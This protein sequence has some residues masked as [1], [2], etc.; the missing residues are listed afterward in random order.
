MSAGRESRLRFFAAKLRGFFRGYE[1]DRELDD[2]ILEHLRLLADKF[3]EQGMSRE[4]AVVAAR[5]QFGN[6]TLLEE[7]RR[8]LQTL[9]SIEALWLDLRYALCIL[10]RS[11]GFAVVSIAT[12]GL[13]IGAATAIFSVID[14]V[15]LQPFPKVRAAWCWFVSSE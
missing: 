5:R 9:P 2:E 11:R 12:L 6:I 14:N 15:L 10:W 3:E 8:A 13:G 4:G 1:R 7:E